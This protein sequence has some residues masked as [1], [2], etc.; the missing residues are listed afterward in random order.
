MVQQR[1]RVEEELGPGGLSTEAR[2]ADGGTV[3]NAAV[4]ARVGAPLARPPRTLW[5]SALE[6]FARH[7]LGVLG[8]GVLGLFLLMGTLGPMVAPYAPEAQDLLSQFSGPSAEHWL[9]TDELGRD[10]FT[11]LLYAARVT[12]FVVLLSTVLATVIGIVVG[13]TAG[14]FGGWV[15]VVLMRLTDVMLSLPVLALLLVVSK[16][17]REMTFL[18]QAFGANNVSIAVLVIILTLFGWMPL[19]RLVHGAVLSLKERE[20]VEAARALGAGA[21]RIIGQHLLPNSMAPII[22]QTTL[23][24]G[25]AVILEGTLSFLGLGITPPNASLGNMLTD[26]QAYVFRNP[27]L[28]VYPGLVIF[29]VVLAINFVGDALRDALDPRMTL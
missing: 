1:E 14:Y 11:R 16:M 6:R 12:L 22:V 26:A 18:R 24:F 28:A 25:T 27:W 15:E 7:W 29:A 9:G 20:F 2:A 4:V 21:G 17:L 23:R 19:A 13:A 8:L 3:G 5:R 10:V